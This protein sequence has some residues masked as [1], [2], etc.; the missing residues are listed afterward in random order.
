[1]GMD[2]LSASMSGAH[3]EVVRTYSPFVG[4]CFIINY[5]VGTGFL[6]IPYIFWHTGIV[7]GV[8]TLTA[9]SHFITF[10]ALWTLEVMARAPVS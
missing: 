6:G 4:F 8:M 7:A 5:I 3:R 9:V 10:P 1:M 2:S